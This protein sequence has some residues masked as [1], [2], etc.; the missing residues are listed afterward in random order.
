MPNDSNETANQGNASKGYTIFPAFS[1]LQVAILVLQGIA[2]FGAFSILLGRVYFLQYQEHLNVPGSEFPQEIS[3]Y[4]VVS[5]DVAITGVGM[6]LLSMVIAASFWWKINPE[7][8]MMVFIV[9]FGILVGSTVSILRDVIG[10]N[11]P[12][13]GLGTF[14]IW[15]L[16]IVAGLVAG[17]ALVF[18]S[19]MSWLTD[20]SIRDNRSRSARR[21]NRF[22][23]SILGQYAA[24]I[25]AVSTVH[26]LRILTVFFLI[27]I[28]LIQAAVV[29]RVDASLALENA[30]SVELR[31]N[32]SRTSDI[33][34]G[35]ADTGTN[36]KDIQTFKL[37]HLGQNFAYIRR[38]EHSCICPSDA[39][40]NIGDPYQFAIPIEEI[41]SIIYIVAPEQ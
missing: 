28:A 16:L 2:A 41:S 18:T 35:G 12:R 9:G 25:L 4:A 29:G 40:L 20:F 15:W 39:G 38:P 3:F 17:V 23:F 32:S 36:Q 5:P 1:A 34:F 19:A 33:F 6:A 26:T 27:S 13:T 37:I 31:F 7:H 8:R 22:S 10:D 21:S 11:I 24:A 14:G 30:P